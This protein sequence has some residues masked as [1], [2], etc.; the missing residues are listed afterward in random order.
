[1][2]GT[3]YICYLIINKTK[4]T[5]Q[6]GTI[7]R[8][9]KHSTN[10]NV[11]IKITNIKLHSKSSIIIDGVQYKVNENILMEKAILKYL[12]K[13]K[14]CPKSMVKYIDSFKR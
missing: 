3:Y 12:S 11:V 6:K 5:L 10:K 13:D 9:L 2:N 8:S 4:P 14:Q 1:M 7:W